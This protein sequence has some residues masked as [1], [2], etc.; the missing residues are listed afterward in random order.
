LRGHELGVIWID[1]GER[2]GHRQPIRAFVRGQIDVRLVVAPF[3]RY[4]G[5]G[6]RGRVRAGT[7]GIATGDA[8]AGAVCEEERP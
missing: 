1:R 2:L 3:K 8:G 5:R 6:E 4:P 7:A